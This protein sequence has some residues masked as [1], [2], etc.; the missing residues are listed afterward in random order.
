V[1]ITTEFVTFLVLVI[2]IVTGAWWRV[3]SV[4]K[5]AKDEAINAAMLA[6]AKAS[7]LADALSAHRLHVAET[8]VSKAGMRE[9]TEQIMDAI[10]G[11]ADRLGQ[12]NE[13]MDRWTESRPPP[14]KTNG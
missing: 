2:G 10:K 3:E 14:R 4:V 8:Y 13:R 5:A 7:V 9:Q 1:T 11:V 6:S 12:I